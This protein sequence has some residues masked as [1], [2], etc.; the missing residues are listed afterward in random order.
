MI[1]VLQD[2]SS[3]A[4]G[5]EVAPFFDLAFPVAGKYIPADHGYALLAAI[6]KK[7]PQIRQFSEIGILTIPGL[8]D[9]QGKIL[10]T[11]QSRCKIR[12]PVS[13]IPLVYPLAGKKLLLGKHE[14]KLGIPQILCLEAADK[15]KAR[16][17]TIK[18]YK[19]PEPFI[20]AAKRQLQQLGIVGEIS[21][22]LNKE[23]KP[24][25]KTVKIK[26]TVVGFTTE[27]WGLSEEDSL[28]LQVRGI[29]GRRHLG[30]GIFDVCEG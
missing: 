7:L 8:G 22:P 6:T 30:C 2:S 18:G 4:S 16:I 24:S 20:E 1:N 9:R 14:I 27:V 12:L 28:K 13:L 5:D 21:I 17:V 23:G 25:R 19:E 10:L 11:S 29:G 26:Q 3:P 15:L